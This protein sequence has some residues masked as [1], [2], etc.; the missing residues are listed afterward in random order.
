MDL[1][2]V[3]EGTTRF[4]FLVRI[5]PPLSLLEAPLFSTTGLELNRDGT[6][7]FV[8]VLKPSEYLDAMGATGLRGLRIATECGIGVTINDRDPGAVHLSEKMLHVRTGRSQ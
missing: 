6:V 7:L 4:L 1:I 5:P 2:E 8:T 3:E